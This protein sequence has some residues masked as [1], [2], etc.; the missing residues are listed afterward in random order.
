VVDVPHLSVPFHLSGSGRFA[1][2]EQDSDAE[3]IQC[4][5]VCLATPEGSRAEVPDYGSPRFEFTLPDANDVIA[6]VTEWEPRVDLSVTVVQAVSGD[7]GLAR[8]TA[9]VSPHLGEDSGP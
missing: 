3:L 6:A 8:I 9:L 5:A 4:V 1:V 7:E 2:V